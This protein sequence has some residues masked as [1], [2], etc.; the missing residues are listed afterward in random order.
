MYVHDNLN[1]KLLIE[2]KK[3]TIKVHS[4][5]MLSKNWQLFVRKKVEEIKLQNRKDEDKL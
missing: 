3:N 2:E 1:T 5:E 4:N